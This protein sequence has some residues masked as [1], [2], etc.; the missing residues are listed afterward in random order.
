MA[1][2]ACSSS[3]TVSKNRKRNS[4]IAFFNFEEDQFYIA[5]YKRRPP[6]PA[7]IVS[8]DNLFCSRYLNFIKSHSFLWTLYLF[9]Q[10]GIFSTRTNLSWLPANF[11]ISKKKTN[12]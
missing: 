5:F 8:L 7:S 11:D 9:R 1:K 10:S 6:N 2:D 12:S 4:F 3:D